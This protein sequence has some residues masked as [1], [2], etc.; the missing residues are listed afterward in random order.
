MEI[1]AM[2]DERNVDA[3]A[4]SETKLKGKGGEWFGNAQ[5]VNILG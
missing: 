1:R 2:F 5:G 3:Q 4:L